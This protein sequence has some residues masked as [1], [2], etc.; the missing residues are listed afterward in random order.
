[1]DFVW[2]LYG[3]TYTVHVTVELVGVATLNLALPA[4]LR[5]PRKGKT[6]PLYKIFL[7]KG[8]L[9]PLQ[10]PPGRQPLDPCEHL[11]QALGLLASL[12]AAS[13]PSML[14]IFLSQ[15]SAWHGI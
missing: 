3:N 14:K 13:A 4:P 12:A 8:A 15:W 1:M 7:G 5:F 2:K 6:A 10:P 11:A 9:P